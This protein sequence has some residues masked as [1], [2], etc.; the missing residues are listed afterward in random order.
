MAFASRTL[1][2]SERNYS[3]VEKE[4]L[5]LVFGFK[6]FEQYIPVRPIVCAN[7]RSQAPHDYLGPETRNTLHRSCSHAAVGTVVGRV[8]LHHTFS[9]HPCT[10]RVPGSTTNA[11]RLCA[12]ARRQL[13]RPLE[14]KQRCIHLG[15]D[16]RRPFDAHLRTHYHLQLLTR[17]RLQLISTIES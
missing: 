8:F 16:S 4:A 13:P 7:H 14:T 5:S 15:S 9:S 17:P 11:N 6:K 3:Q 12:R 1:S 10:C 2:T